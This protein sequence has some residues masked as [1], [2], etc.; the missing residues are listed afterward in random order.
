MKDRCDWMINPSVFQQIQQS[1]GPLHINL[2]ASQIT[3]QLPRFYSWRPGR[4]NRFL[5]TKLDSGEGLCQSPMVPDFSLS[6]SDKETTSESSSG[7]TTLAIPTMVS[8][9]S[10]NAGG[11]SPLTSK[12]PRS[13]LEPNQPGVHNETGS[14][15]TGRM[16]HL[17]E[18]FASRGISTQASDLLLSSWRDK[19][20]SNYNSVCKVG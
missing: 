16:A 17:R 7:D 9:A 6:E 3:K 11:P 8:S 2:F 12:H 15:K 4:S 10:R 1:I 13:N 18:S 20:N 19:T 5:H 14:A